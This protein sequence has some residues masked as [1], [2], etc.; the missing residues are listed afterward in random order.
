VSEA[1]EEVVGIFARLREIMKHRLDMTVEEERSREEQSKE[2]RERLER[3][4]KERN[5]LNAQLK[6]DQEERQKESAEMDREEQRLKADTKVVTDRFRRAMAETE[7]QEV[8]ERDE[9]A[10]HYRL[11]KE[12][13]EKEREELHRKLRSMR[14]RNANLE[15]QEKTNKGKGMNNL[16]ITLDEYDDVMS[17]LKEVLE[18]KEAAGVRIE[19]ELRE[20]RNQTMVWRDERLAWE[21]QERERAKVELSKE[22]RRMRS[23]MAAEVV[24]AWWRGVLESRNKGKK[25]KKGKKK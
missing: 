6:M 14:E 10:E 18:E 13:L 8:K 9:D 25:G 22:M 23:G 5:V 12:R 24:Q 20:M 7:D 1:C 16:Q 2:T 21:R 17:N 11:E 3:N 4:K 15:Q 19:E